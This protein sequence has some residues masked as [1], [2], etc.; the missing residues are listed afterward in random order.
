[1]S[2]TANLLERLREAH[3]REGS[4]EVYEIA[5]QVLKHTEK[6]LVTLTQGIIGEFGLSDQ[7]VMPAVN[8]AML[9]LFRYM[10]KKNSFNDSKHYARIAGKTI[11]RTLLRLRRITSKRREHLLHDEAILTSLPFVSP[12]PSALAGDSLDLQD[13]AKKLTPR[14]RQVV[15]LSSY[16][17][18]AAEMGQELGIS[19]RAVNKI[20]EK[21]RSNDHLRETFFPNKPNKDSR[22]G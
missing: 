12:D 9:R 18:S 22:N 17:F 19:E 13:C 20:L 8:E 4:K 16:G 3:A 5:E 1:M 15:Y 10:M 7:Y 11:W 21:I 2:G 6:R 14:E